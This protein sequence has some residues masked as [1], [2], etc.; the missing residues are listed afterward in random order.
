M[1]M[2]VAE[3]QFATPGLG[4]LGVPPG[5]GITRP[6][7]PAD[8]FDADICS[9]I[10][11]GPSPVMSLDACRSMMGMQQRMQASSSDPS[12]VRPGDENLSCAG[13]YD[14]IRASGWP[15]MSQAT[16]AQNQQAGS[17]AMATLEQQKADTR[18]F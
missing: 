5:R 13:I 8:D 10:A 15:M 9:D 3:A 1:S 4:G 2:G 14:E 18:G 17:A 6:A 12:A 7:E 16:I 11:S